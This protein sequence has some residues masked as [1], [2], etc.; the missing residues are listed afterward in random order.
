MVIKKLGRELDGQFMQVRQW[1]VYAHVYRLS[2]P[3]SH[4]VTLSHT[5]VT[6]TSHTHVT[7]PLACAQVVSYLTDTE[8]MD[9]VV[10]PRMYD[11]AAAAGLSLERIFTYS[12]AEEADRLVC[13]CVCLLPTLELQ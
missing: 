1:R 2:H 11:A 3:R 5:H 12:D 4:S 9:V 7:A 8:R 6:H 10:E 13:A